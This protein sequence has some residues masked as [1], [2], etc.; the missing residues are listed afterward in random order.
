MTHSETEGGKM[1]KLTCGTC[2]FIGGVSWDNGFS[3]EYYC[4]KRDERRRDGFRTT[5]DYAE[6]FMQE[7]RKFY[8][9]GVRQKAC[10]YYEPCQP[11]TPD[12]RRI[13]GIL[14]E[15]DGRAS[16][17]FLTEDSRVASVHQNKYW[18]EDP[19]PLDQRGMRFY[20]LTDLGKLHAG[21]MAAEAVAAIAL[22]TKEQG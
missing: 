14:S 3:L 19:Y 4:G 22:A 11:V 2:T 12:E 15:N 10:K 9:A 13:I 7:F 16:F 8:D 6:D 20:R 5:G 1:E 21:I 18:R 17:K